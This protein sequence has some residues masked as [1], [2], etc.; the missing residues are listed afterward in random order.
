MRGST[1]IDWGNWLR[2]WLGVLKRECEGGGVQ[3]Y[4]YRPKYIENRF[5]GSSLY[6]PA[7]VF[8]RRLYSPRFQRS[9]SCGSFD[10]FDSFLFSAVDA[11]IS[12][13]HSELW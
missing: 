9:F 6:L 4:K 11:S 2:R 3:G 12:A 7:Y 8:E 1:E 13:Q 10:C 5:L